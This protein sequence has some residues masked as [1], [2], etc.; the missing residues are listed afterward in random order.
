MEQHA[1]HQAVRVTAR[2][3][4]IAALEK[5]I[6]CLRGQNI[7]VIGRLERFHKTFLP[8]LQNFVRACAVFVDDG[9][10]AKGLD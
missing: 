10:R 2:D 8:E 9:T 4:Y 6:S 3:N 7:D 1:A 5:E